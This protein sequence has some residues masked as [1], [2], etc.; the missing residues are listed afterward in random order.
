MRWY[1]NVLWIAGLVL[2]VNG[3][4]QWF[5][6]LRAERDPDLIKRTRRIAATLVGLGFVVLVV[7]AVL[8]WG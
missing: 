6:W 8:V 5:G 7:H 2:V 4:L 1:E 3:L